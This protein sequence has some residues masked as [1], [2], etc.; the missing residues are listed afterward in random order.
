MMMR[1][2]ALLPVYAAYT[3]NGVGK[4]GPTKYIFYGDYHDFLGDC[5]IR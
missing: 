4:L 1:T 2:P 5:G 3:F